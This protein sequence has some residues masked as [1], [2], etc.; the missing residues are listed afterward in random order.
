MTFGPP[1][2][3]DEN[4]MWKTGPDGD[5]AVA[6]KVC[7]HSFPAANFSTTRLAAITAHAAFGGV[8]DPASD[9]PHA[10]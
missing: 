2:P 4:G 6:P 9:V 1:S 5:Y 10:E 8:D 3:H 7:C